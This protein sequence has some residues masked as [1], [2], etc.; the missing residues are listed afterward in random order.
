MV[1]NLLSSR[2]WLFI[3]EEALMSDG[4]QF[5]V[6]LV[7]GG[8]V[9]GAGWLRV[10]RLLKEERYQGSVVQNPT[11]SLA[12]DVAAAKLVLDQQDRP[13]ILVGHSYGGVVISEA[14]NHSKVVGLVYIAVFAPD[15]VSRW[16]SSSPIRSLAP[17]CPQSYRCKMASSFSTRQI[18]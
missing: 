10:Y 4:Q 16:L 5:N 3:S 18:P 7:H 6:V 2:D 1:A 8:F 12:V 14:G 17:P 15:K 13:T 9:D 11:T